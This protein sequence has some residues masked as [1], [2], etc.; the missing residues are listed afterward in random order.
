MWTYVSYKIL[1]QV[2]LV[3]CAYLWN[4]AKWKHTSEVSTISDKINS[5]VFLNE[6]GRIDGWAI[7]EN[8][9]QINFQSVVTLW[10][11]PG[12]YSMAGRWHRPKFTFL[13]GVWVRHSL[14]FHLS[15]RM[16]LLIATM[17]ALM[18]TT[19]PG[20]VSIIRNQIKYIKTIRAYC[21]C[22]AA[23]RHRFVN[24]EQSSIRDSTGVIQAPTHSHTHI[25]I[26]RYISINTKNEIERKISETNNSS[27]KCQRVFSL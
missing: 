12:G 17:S 24:C 18:A 14:H 9:T 11:P 8:R 27:L 25:Q 21:E 19:T 6:I 22:D 5:M 13:M 10:F 23:W 26:Y 3:Q 15:K 1:L 16:F 2:E 4:C 20:N 7:H